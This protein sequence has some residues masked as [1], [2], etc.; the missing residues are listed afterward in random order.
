MLE[1]EKQRIFEALLLFTSQERLTRWLKKPNR[2][3]GG[4]SPN[5][6]INM[7]NTGP[8]WRFIGELRNGY[9]F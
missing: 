8:V 1:N 6:L 5:A 3:W 9:P 2:E 4:L 7:G